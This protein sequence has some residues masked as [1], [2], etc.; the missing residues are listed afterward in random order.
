MRANEFACKVISALLA[1]V[2]LGAVL[3]FLMS[4]SSKGAEPRFVVENRCPPAFTVESRLPPP[5]VAAPVVYYAAPSYAA[6]VCVG[7][8]CAAPVQ[9]RGRLFTGRGRLLPTVRK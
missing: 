7:G 4:L 5:P 3:G 2:A 8:S 9:T 1:L 6:P